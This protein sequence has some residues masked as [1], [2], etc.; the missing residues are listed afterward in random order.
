MAHIR[1]TDSQATPRSGTANETSGNPILA[2]GDRLESGCSRSAGSGSLFCSQGAMKHAVSDTSPSSSSDRRRIFIS[3]T[4]REEEVRQLK[5]LVD[6][7]L[8]ALPE[9]T[10]R[11]L[12]IWYDGV[13]LSRNQGLSRQELAARLSAALRTC[14]FTL[15]FISPHYLRSA[16]C[17]HEWLGSIRLTFYGLPLPV[18]WKPTRY[19]RHY[20]TWVAPYRRQ[21]VSLIG[22]SLEEAVKELI[23]SVIFFIR[24]REVPP[25]AV[26]LK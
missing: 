24:H 17:R 22:L 21:W 18:C 16:W 9:A 23:S 7:F 3:Y 25:P 6:A 12:G 2:L 13:D 1:P 4:T 20:A 15:A 14:D 10:Y 11:E 5:P 26:D 8:L 19:F